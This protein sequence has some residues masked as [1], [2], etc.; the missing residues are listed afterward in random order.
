MH[1]NTFTDP[2]VSIETL[3]NRFLIVILT[4]YLKY[5]IY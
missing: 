4:N 2:I 1:Y 3:T 5:V